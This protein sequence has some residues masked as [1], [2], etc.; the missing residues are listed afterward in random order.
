VYVGNCGSEGGNGSDAVF[1][2]STAALGVTSRGF[3][4]ENCD[5]RVQTD[6]AEEYK[7]QHSQTVGNCELGV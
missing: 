3:G 7:R 2:E 1:R 4:A 5:F 6:S